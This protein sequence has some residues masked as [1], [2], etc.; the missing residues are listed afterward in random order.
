MFACKEEN[1]RFL[2]FE[3]TNWV[4]QI[5]RPLK[6]KQYKLLRDAPGLK[7]AELEAVK[8]SFQ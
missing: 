6:K 2:H 7:A 8:D 1:V 5:K 3:F 4:T